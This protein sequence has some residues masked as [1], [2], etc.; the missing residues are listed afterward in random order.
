M[1]A[2]NCQAEWPSVIDDEIIDYIANAVQI[3]EKSGQDA[4]AIVISAGKSVK[5]SVDIPKET[6]QPYLQFGFPNQDSQDFLSDMKILA[7][8]SQDLLSEC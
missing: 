1:I 2:V 7:K 4:S 3:L 8:D 6:L 5:P